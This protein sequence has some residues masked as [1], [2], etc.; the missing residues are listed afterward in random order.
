MISSYEKCHSGTTEIG[1]SWG[2][3]HW[4]WKQAISAFLHSLVTCGLHHNPELPGLTAIPLEH[5]ALC[6]CD[7]RSALSSPSP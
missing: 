1:L 3:I 7:T 5:R 2:V 4:K 6:L